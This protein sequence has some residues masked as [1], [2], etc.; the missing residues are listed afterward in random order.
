MW[1]V[2]PTTAVIEKF[3]QYIYTVNE[4]IY[5]PFS[6]EAAWLTESLSIVGGHLL[7]S[8]DQEYRNKR[9]MNRKSSER[10][11]GITVSAQQRARKCRRRNIQLKKRKFKQVWI[12]FTKRINLK[13][14]RFT[15]NSGRSSL[16]FVQKDL[17]VE[18][19]LRGSNCLRQKRVRDWI[20]T[21]CSHCTRRSR[22]MYER[23]NYTRI[24]VGL[25]PS[26]QRN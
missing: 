7:S 8:P 20:T 12:E 26:C 4:N 16:K 5:L 3:R 13:W 25:F 24:T 23:T 15:D 17:E 2:W 1:L 19:T 14:R 9:G 11:P 22:G 10:A 6:V 21:V 18:D